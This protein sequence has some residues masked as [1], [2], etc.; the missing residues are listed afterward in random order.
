MNITGI[1]GLIAIFISLSL[2][3][4]FIQKAKTNREDRRE[5][6]KERQQKHLDAVLRSLAEKDQT[7]NEDS[8][9]T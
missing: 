7:E 5:R 1:W 6:S 4:Y 3:Y 2:F 9:I 8:E